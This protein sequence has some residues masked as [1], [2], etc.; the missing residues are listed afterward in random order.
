ML[1]IIQKKSFVSEIMVSELVALNCFY[2]EENTCNR[3]SMCQQT[4]LRFSVALT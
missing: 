1:N 4:V 3:Q 2:K